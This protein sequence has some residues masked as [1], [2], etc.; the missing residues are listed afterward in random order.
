MN[1]PSMTTRHVDRAVLAAHHEIV[2]ISERERHGGDSYGF[3]LLEHQL[4]AVL[5]GE[6]RGG[7][8]GTTS[9]TRS[10]LRLYINTNSAKH[11]L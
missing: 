1:A 7:G 5:W 2:D 4:H 9:L 11:N 3:G 10:L 6:G 8:H